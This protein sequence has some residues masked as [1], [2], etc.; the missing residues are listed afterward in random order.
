MPAILGLALVACGGGVA[1][2]APAAQTP[3]QT[4]ETM[5]FSVTSD[6][7]KPGEAIPARYTCQGQDVSPRLSWSGQPGNTASFA[8]IVGDPDAPGGTFTHWVMFNLPAAVTK[9]PEGVPKSDTIENGAIQGKNSSGKI[10]YMGPCPPAG[11]QHHY[12]FTVYAL[13]GTLMLSPG[14][15]KQQVLSAMDGHVLGQAQLVG[16]YQK[17]Q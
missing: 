6:A 8:L 5:S 7:F 10:G 15:S 4:E 9:L 3:A 1:T 12:Q 2:Q 17:G 13:D 14:A 11:K 16:T